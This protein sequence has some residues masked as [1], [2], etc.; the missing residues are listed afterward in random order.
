MPSP[1]PT[2][3]FPAE[4]APQSA[5]MLTWPHA[6]TDWAPDLEETDACFLRI[7]AAVTRHESLIVACPDTA[8]AA[9]LPERITEAGG[10]GARVHAFVAAAND[11]WARDHGPLSVV[12]NGHTVL[13]DFAFNGW[14][15]KYPA[16]LDNQVTAALQRQGAYGDTPVETVPLVM[17]GGSLESD[18]EGTL[19]T[20]SRC[21]LTPTRN[22][23]LGRAALEHALQNY[24]GAQRVLWLEHGGLEGDDTDGH[25]DT[26]A[27]FCNPELI[28]YQ[29][30][31]DRDDPHYAELAAMRDELESL[32]RP[33]GQPYRLAALPWPQP[34]YDRH[35]QRLPATYANFLIINDAVLM[36]GYDDPAD[37]QAQTVL[38]ECFPGRT[39]EVLDCRPLIRGFGSLHCVTMQL[40]AGVVAAEDES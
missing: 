34:Q 15:G 14:G 1:E 25:I 4:W 26:L 31:N 10:H 2:V 23:G 8:F 40:P 22:P 21:L 29:A 16:E 11:T 13:L 33:D 9:R 28:A 19:L 32:R 17:E 20:T 18:G 12:R 7:A 24:L 27:R 30:C 37:A 5:V 6:G 36:P 38:A 3:V 35:G 39:V